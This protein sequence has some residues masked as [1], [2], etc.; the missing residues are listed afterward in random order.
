MK[1]Y[2]KEFYWFVIK[3]GY[4]SIFGAVLL[5]V[6][7]VTEYVEV[8]FITRYDFIFLSAILTQVILIATKKETKGEVL[9]IGVFHFLATMMELFK[10]SPEI[11]SWFYP[12]QG[13]F[14]IATVPLFSGFLYSAVGS[15]L[16][17]VWRA[18]KF[19]FTNY[20][21]FLHTAIV[22][23]LIYI[24]FFTHHFIYDIRLL[25]FIAIAYL[26]YKTQIYFTVLKKERSM[27]L[28]LGFFLVTLFIWIAENAG[29][30]FSVW[31]YPSQI[32]GWELVGFQKIGSWFLLMVVSFVLISSLHRK[33]LKSSVV[34]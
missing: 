4:A 26:Y 20:P 19:R 13:F 22:A 11:E 21:N 1:S 33:E 16:A 24:N 31:L 27:P 8:P 32:D 30:F 25:L 12:D 9:M 6:F 5:F 10:T 17:R 2:A 34:N 18:F 7:L 15:Y 23:T 14:M 3:Q 29:T 28:L